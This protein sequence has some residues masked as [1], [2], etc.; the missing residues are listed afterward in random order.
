MFGVIGVGGMG[1]HHARVYSELG[2]LSV[3]Y[4]LDYDRAVQIG[5]LYRAHAAGSLDDLLRYNLEGVTVA[6]PTPNHPDTVA[7]CLRAGLHVLCEKPLAPSL[8]EAK[9]MVELAKASNLTLAVGYIEKFNPV[10]ETVVDLYRSGA[11]GEL[12]SVNIKRVG[13]AARSAYNVVL[14][15]MTHDLNLLLNLLGKCP[16]KVYSHTHR[17]D[18]VLDSAQ[19]LLDFG[20]TSATCEANWLTPI[21]IRSM[22]ITGTE[23]YCEVDL[24]AQQLTSY[25][26]AKHPNFRN[27]TTGAYTLD[28]LSFRE[29]PLRRELQA[30]INNDLEELVLGQEGYD[31]LVLTLQ[32]FGENK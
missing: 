4:D 5:K 9:E 2:K 26:S 11:F 25:S 20:S 14:D 17:K 32:A 31:T 24:I 1:Q 16:D 12:T 19:V 27:N 10:F 6:T 21:K 15:L 30:F 28:I 8:A 29:E 18:G 3:V 13:G 7:Q 22:Q 23:G